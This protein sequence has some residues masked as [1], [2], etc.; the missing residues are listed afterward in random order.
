MAS[1]Y[2]TYRPSGGL[3][4]EDPAL[5]LQESEVQACENF[6]F[7]RSIA[8]SRPGVSEKSPTLTGNLFFGRSL[9]F[10]SSVKTILLTDSPKMYSLS[11]AFAA[12]EITGAGLALGSV[13]SAASVNGIVLVGDNTGGL[14]RWDTSGAVYTLLAAAPYKYVTSHL[15]RA[16]AAHKLGGSADPRSVA[17]SVAG[18][19]T[20]WTGFGSGATVLADAADE[21]TGLA[22]ARNTVVV[23]RSTGFHL[24]TPT[25]VSDPAFNWTLHSK[26]AVGCQY[27]GTFSA[28]GTLCFF[29]GRSDVHRFD[30]VSVT[31]IGR[32]IRR[33]LIGYLAGGAV[34]RGF[35]SESYGSNARAHY[36]LVPMSSSILPHFAYD[37]EEGKWSRHGY[38]KPLNGGWYMLLGADSAPV[39]ISKTDSKLELWDETLECEIAG[40][41]TGRILEVGPLTEDFKYN[42]CLLVHRNFSELECEVTVAADQGKV[43]VE[44]SKVLKLSG[45]SRW[46]RTWFDFR[47]TGQLPYVK[48]STK[49][50]LEVFQADL[51][52]D[53]A[54]LM[55]EG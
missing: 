51:Q 38:E 43:A 17:W 46:R 54:G 33:E 55:R 22:M 14:I 45:D 37:I 44:E 1:S 7:E 12:T 41:I 27:P 8:L 34:Y 26:E 18:D 10:S 49:G 9:D 5:A 52:V 47:L 21:I 23:V 25:G 13:G 24:G 31:P 16:V 3:N 32:N 50:H 6:L 35:I 48:L 36:H 19:E 28:Y 39:L 40:Y 2:K 4:S 42:R 11:S 53:P 30:L 29:V 15:S 20:D